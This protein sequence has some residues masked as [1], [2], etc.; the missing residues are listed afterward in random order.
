MIRFYRA[1][2]TAALFAASAAPALAQNA[3]MGAP[4]DAAPPA[5][6]RTTAVSDTVPAKDAPAPKAHTHH[7]RHRH[8]ATH[9][10]DANVPVAAQ[11]GN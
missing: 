10:T 2:L 4:S 9:K 1:A 5:P 8:V 7:A 3:P 6:L 11:A